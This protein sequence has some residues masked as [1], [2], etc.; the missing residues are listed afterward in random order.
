MVCNGVET[1]G[2]G[3]NAIA[4]DRYNNWAYAIRRG[5]VDF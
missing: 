2:G 3:C 4:R 5:G 1:C